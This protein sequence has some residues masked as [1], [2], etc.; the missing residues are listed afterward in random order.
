MLV[1]AALAA[2]A[3][4]PQDQGGAFAKHLQQ[5]PLVGTGASLRSPRGRD[6]YN[7]LSMAYHCDSLTYH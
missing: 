3:G 1:R 4:P 2:R 7:D 6:H 5:F